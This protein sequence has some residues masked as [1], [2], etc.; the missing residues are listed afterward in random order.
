[1]S[2][3]DLFLIET[4]SF[5]SQRKKTYLLTSGPNEYD[6]FLPSKLGVKRPI[7]H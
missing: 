5:E 6:D 3:L 2:F 1:M 4:F 7:S